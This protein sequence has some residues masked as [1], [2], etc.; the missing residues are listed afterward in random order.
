MSLMFNLEMIQV[1]E[2]LELDVDVKVLVLIG[3]GDVWM[4]G[5]D[6]KEYFCEV[7]VGLEI[8]QEKICCDVCQW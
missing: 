5:M 2:V 8:L 4:V 1:F 7:D 6:L 3:V